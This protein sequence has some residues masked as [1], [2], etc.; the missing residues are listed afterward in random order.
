MDL[1]ALMVKD[2]LEREAKLAKW[3]EDN[4]R[5]NTALVKAYSNSVRCAVLQDRDDG[6]QGIVIT[7]DGDKVDKLNY[8]IAKADFEIDHWNET[9]N[10]LYTLL[11]I[12]QLEQSGAVPGSKSDIKYQKQIISLKGKIHAAELKM[13][14]AKFD[15]EQ[16]QRKLGIA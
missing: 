10:E 13:G 3:E 7:V 2:K 14:K 15:R 1:Y 9:A 8:Q 6:Q 12:A 11:D 4:R 5:R 16:A